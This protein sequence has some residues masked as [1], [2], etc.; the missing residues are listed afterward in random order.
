[1]NGEGEESIWSARL[2]EFRDATAS[3]EP[4]PGGGSVAAVAATLGLGLVIMAL[5]ISARRKDALL[6]EETTSLIAEA[7]TLMG[8]LGGDA[9]GDIRAFRAYMAALKLPKQSDD[10][11]ARRKEAL[12]AATH[13]ATEAPLLAARHIVEALRLATPALPLAHPHV[14]SDVGAGAGLLEGH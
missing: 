14:A 3:A 10:E 7:R 11:K 5:E 4:T 1:M 8:G 6:P 2:D 12:R 13:R 9:D